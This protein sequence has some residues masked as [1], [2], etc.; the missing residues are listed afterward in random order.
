MLWGMALFIKQ[1]YKGTM[2]SLKRDRRNIL[3]R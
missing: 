2:V 3:E 1:I